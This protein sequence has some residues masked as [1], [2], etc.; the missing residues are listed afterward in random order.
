MEIYKKTE[1]FYNSYKGKKTVIGKSEFGR[2]IYAFFVGEEGRTVGICQYAIHAREWITA[3]LAF[4]QIECGVAKGGVWFI[5]LMNPDGAELCLNGVQSVKS[6]ERK[7]YLLS[8]NGEKGN[9]FS[10]WKANGNGVDLNVNFDVGWGKGEKNLFYPSA[11]NYVGSRP[12]SEPETA[13]LRDFT[14]SV[15]PDFTISYHTSG[16]EIYWYYHQPVFSAMRDRKYGA[17]LSKCTGYPLRYSNSS[18]GGYK[19][20]CISAL[21]IPSYTV[22]AGRGAQPIG[23]DGLKDITEKNLLSVRTFTRNFAR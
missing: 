3:L 6:E 2:N 21:K 18:H 11:E 12:F 19:D 23:M 13:S 1:K 5:P 16:E 20:W 7:K 10:L 9:D 17:I 22:E 4:R 14:F 15:K 8:L